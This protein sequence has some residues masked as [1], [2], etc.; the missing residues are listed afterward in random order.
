MAGGL[1][2]EPRLAE[3]ESAVLPLDDPPETSRA[4]IQELRSKVKAG[5][6]VAALKLADQALE[7]SGEFSRLIDAAMSCLL[8]VNTGF[9]PNVKLGTQLATRPFGN[10]EKSNEFLAR[11]AFV[12][13]RDI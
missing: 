13:L 4:K 12:V 2:F 6:L 10:T 9:N 11:A 1:G 5:N 8:V 7:H 3:S